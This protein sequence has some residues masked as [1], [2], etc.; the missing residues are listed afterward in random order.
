[1]NS[2]ISVFIA[3][4]L[5][6]YIAR[7]DGSIDWLDKANESVP[8]N[9]DCGFH[10]F[11]ETIDALIMGRKTF[12]QVLS[13]GKWPYDDKPVIVLSSQRNII[14][15]ALTKTV[16]VRSGEPTAI[17]KELTKDR[18]KH[19]YIDGG[20]TIQEFLSEGLVD[21]ITITLIPVILGNGKPLFGKLSRDVKLQHIETKT[22]DFG[23]VQNKYR[24]IK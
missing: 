11:M 20:F 13:F 1:M 2:K 15:E 23:F 19:F 3:T 17:I 16:M 24:V 7:E 8:A 14:P 18:P 9:E 10:K 4:S 6:G 12:E 21:E 22:Y 5:D